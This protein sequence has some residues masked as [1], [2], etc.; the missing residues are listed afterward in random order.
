MKELRPIKLI[1]LVI[2]M[3]SALCASWT[4]FDICRMSRI[5]HVK[6]FLLLIA[7]G[8]LITGLSLVMELF[9]GENTLTCAIALYGENFGQQIAIVSSSV[10]G[11]F[12]FK[13]VT[14]LELDN[15]DKYVKKCIWFTIIISFLLE[16]PPCFPF[17]VYTYGHA[18]D[19]KYMRNEA[20]S[21]SVFVTGTLAMGLLEIV[22]FLVVSLIFYMKLMYY[23]KS[24]FDKALKKT[25][26]LK[27]ERLFWYPLAQFVLYFPNALW[28][29]DSTLRRNF[30]FDDIISYSTAILEASAGISTAVLYY[31]FS[32]SLDKREELLNEEIRISLVTND[33][34]DFHGGRYASEYIL[35]IN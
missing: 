5:S 1:V 19:C 14:Q 18:D 30:A 34:V 6:Q 7:F 29:L 33:E 4:I 31:F 13:S 28:W 2:Q 22:P 24:H 12:A 26:F 25:R 21:E 23:L 15:F 10:L 16:T 8:N 9:Y 3:I 20:I 17:F 27:I 11:I 35:P 32:K